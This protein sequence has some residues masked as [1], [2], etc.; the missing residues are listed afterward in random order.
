MGV[1]SVL[2]REMYGPVGTPTAFIT[3]FGWVPARSVQGNQQQREETSYFA[4]TLS[5]DNLLRKFWEVEDCSFGEPTLSNEERAVMK[6]FIEQHR[7]DDIG[8]FI[9][10]LPRKP[11]VAPLGESRSIAVKRFL[12]VE[13]S[14]KANGRAQEFADSVMEYFDMD[15]AEPV[16]HGRSHRSGRIFFL[17]PLWI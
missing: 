6:H 4:S 11:D 5:C 16:P 7:R 12:T 10:P 2:V 15:H 17:E 8:R 1:Q 14:L 13:R 3:R 9:V